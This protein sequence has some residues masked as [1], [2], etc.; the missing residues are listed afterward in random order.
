M[1]FS[2]AYAILQQRLPGGFCL[3]VQL[4]KHAC[5]HA[6][7]LMF[8]VWDVQKQTHYRKGATLAAAVAAVERPTA[9]ACRTLAEADAL[10]ELTPLE[11]AASQG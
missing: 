6:P 9:D 1:T 8:D 11:P 10:G 7:V 5:D 3:Q 2:D 4:W